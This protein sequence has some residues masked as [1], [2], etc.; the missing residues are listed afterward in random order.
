MLLSVKILRYTSINKIE[1]MWFYIFFRGC[2]RK[3]KKYLEENSI[4]NVYSFN[5]SF[6]SQ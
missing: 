5:I 3:R 6:Y 1:Q 2:K 4:L